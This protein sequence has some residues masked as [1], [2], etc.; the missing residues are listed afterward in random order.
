MNNQKGWVK[1]ELQI[2]PSTNKELEEMREK[3]GLPVSH[4]VR[5]AINKY[6]EDSKK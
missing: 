5:T 1:R 6:I 4:L 2:R 3:T